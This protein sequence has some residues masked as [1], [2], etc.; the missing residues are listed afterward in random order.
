MLAQESSLLRIGALK[1]LSNV[2]IK[3]I[4][5]YEELGLIQATKRTEG[6]FRLFSPDILHRLTFIK[7][8]QSLG[9]SLQEIGEILG[10]YDQGELPCIEV[11]HKFAAKIAEIDHKI[12]QLALLKAQLQS[13]VNQALPSPEQTE[14][15]ICPLIEQT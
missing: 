6:G 14:G 5:Y 2:P 3:T 1:A 7:R 10:I 13:L 11:R 12:E 9:L 4:R 8:A 15:T